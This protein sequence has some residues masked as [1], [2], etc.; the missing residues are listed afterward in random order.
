MRK[1]S[2]IRRRLSPM[3]RVALLAGSEKAVALHLRR[4]DDVNATDDHG[5][6]ALML[7]ASRGHASIC[8]LLLDA[9]ANPSLRDQRERDALIIAEQNGWREVAAL[10]LPALVPRNDDLDK[11]DRNVLHDCARGDN[12]IEPDTFELSA[13]ES[14]AQT[15]PPIAIE[16][17]VTEAYKLQ[18]KISEHV[19]VDTDEEWADIEILLPNL[20]RRS[21]LTPEQRGA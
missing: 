17:F 15:L 2:L 11:G 14:Y 20:R 1:S 3:F 18:R 19:V 4:G 9:G 10:L 8:Q 16:T 5:T 12:G 7:A 21:A 13:W 6:T